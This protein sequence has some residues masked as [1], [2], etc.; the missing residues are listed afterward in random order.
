MSIIFRGIASRSFSKKFYTTIASN[1]AAK[2]LAGFSLQTVITTLENFAPK[3][4][5]ESWDNTGLLVEPY[6]DRCVCLII[7]SKN[8][9]FFYM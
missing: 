1:M 2:E 7:T 5:S 8:T 3:E 4:L 9:F 6:T